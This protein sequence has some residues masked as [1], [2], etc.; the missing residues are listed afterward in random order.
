M[1]AMDRMCRLELAFWS[2][3][4][5]D[6]ARDRVQASIEACLPGVGRPMLL[7]DSLYALDKLGDTKLLVFAGAW[8]Q[9]MFKTV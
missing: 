5:G 8:M 3:T 9:S 7:S 6:K 4:F 1:Q 2:S